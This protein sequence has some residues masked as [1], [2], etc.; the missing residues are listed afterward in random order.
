MPPFVSTILTFLVYWVI[1]FVACYMI[2]E[3]AQSYLYDETT[4]SAGLKVAL[5]TFLF[6]AFLTWKRISFESMFGGDLAWMFGLAV[7]WFVIFTFLFRFHPPHAFAIGLLSC[8]LLTGAATLA[9]NSMTGQTPVTVAA[10]RAT[11]K[12]VRTTLQTT[13]P[14][15]P[16]APAESKANPQPAATP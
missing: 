9:V 10:K 8:I 16:A 1:L 4:P 5:G 14:A 11:S 7:A 6:A 13:A 2:V 12:P 3:Y 15:P